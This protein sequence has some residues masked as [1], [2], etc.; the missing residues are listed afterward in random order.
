MHARALHC[1]LHLAA[2]SSKRREA[3]GAFECCLRRRTKQPN[4][5]VKHPQ[6]KE[7]TNNNIVSSESIKRCLCVLNRKWAGVNFERVDPCSCSV[8]RPF[9]QGHSSGSRQHTLRGRSFWALFP[10]RPRIGPVRASWR[11]FS[12]E[13]PTFGP[14]PWPLQLHARRRLQVEFV[15]VV[16]YAVTVVRSNSISGLLLR[17]PKKSRRGVQAR[18]RDQGGS[19]SRPSIDD[20]PTS[21]CM[22]DWWEITLKLVWIAT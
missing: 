3:S 8:T 13:G 21:P 1:S 4:A 20:P 18:P 10:P 12:I 9:V 15:G 16:G 22:V 7:E 5:N 2:P 6:Q 17:L 19:C 14:N 11:T